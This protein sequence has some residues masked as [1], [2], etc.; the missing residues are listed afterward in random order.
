MIKAILPAAGYGK[1]M[2]M[3]INQSKEMLKEVNGENFLIDYSLN[4]CYKYNIEPVVISRIE[5]EDLNSYLRSKQVE[6]IVLKKPGSEWAETVLKSRGLWGEKN[7]LILPDT[8]WDDDKNKAFERIKT[9]ISYSDQQLVAG[10][11]IINPEDSVKW[12]TLN[13]DF[14][15]EKCQTQAS[16]AWGVLAFS[17]EIGESLFRELT[18]GNFTK[19]PVRYNI[20]LNNF[21]D[22]TRTGKLEE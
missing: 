6:H 16:M 11:H 10:Y 21:R 12:G 9:C 18:P 17:K 19:L 20:K 13:G 1:R 15:L 22:I 14:I 2:G 3:E 4:L 5:K 7:I 8:R